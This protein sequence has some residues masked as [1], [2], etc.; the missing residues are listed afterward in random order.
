[1]SSL[2][3][4]AAHQMENLDRGV[5]AVKVTDG[6]FVSWRYLGT[7]DPS[8]GFNLYRDDRKV[9]NEVITTSTNY[10]DA[11]GSANSIY[12]VRAVINGVERGDS[13]KANVWGNQYLTVK[14]NRPGTNYTP[15]DMSVGDVDGDGTYELF[16][17]WDPS[18][19]QDVANKGKTDLVYIDC[20][21]MAGKQLWRINL[22][23]NIRAGAHYTQFQVFDYDGDGKAEMVCKTAPG[24]K[25]GNGKNIIMGNDDP[26]KDYRNGDGYIITGPEYLTAF[27][28]ETGAEM[29]TVAYKPARGNVSSWGDNYGNRVDRFLACTAYLDGVHP[30]VVMCRGYYTRA[31]LTAYDFK[32]GKL[33]E[34]W[35][36]DSPNKGQGA[37]GDG[38]HNLSVADAD[39]D[40]FDEIIY[41]SS[42]IDHD[43]KL[44]YRTG[45]AHGDAMHVSDMDPDSPGL[46]LFTVHESTGGKYGHNLS[47]LKDGKVL[48]GRAPGADDNG[49]GLAADIDASHRGF[50]FWSSAYGNI[51]DCKGTSI[52][53][54]PS[55]ANFRVYWDG[56]LQDELLDGNKIDKW[57]GNGTTRLFTATGSSSING[58]K[59]VPN[60]CADILGDWREEVIWY[61]SSNPSEIRI[62]TTTIATKNRLFTLMH[63][64]VYRCAI[65]WQNTA[66]NQPPHLGFYIGDGLQ[67]VKQPDIF[68]TGETPVQKPSLSISSES[69]TVFSGNAIE[70]ITISFGGSATGVEIAELPAGLTKT[71]IANGF[72][73]SG[74]STESCTIT[75]KSVGGEGDAVTKSIKINVISTTLKKVAYITDPAAANYKN[76]TKILSALK[77]CEDLYVVEIDANQATDLSQYDLIVISEVAGSGATL[78]PALE[79]I[80]KPMLSMKVH[81]YKAGAWDWAIEGYGDDAEATT[82]VVNNDMLKHPMFKDVTFTNGN[83]VRIL[84]E[85]DTKGLTF[86]NPESFTQ[87]SGEIKGIASIKG[88]TEVNILEASAGS[89]IAGTTLKNDF[90]QIGINS[91]S[92]ANVT[93]DGVSIIKNAC[94]Y[95]LGSEE[96]QVEAIPSGISTSISVF[97]N[98]VVDRLNIKLN[99]SRETEINVTLTNMIGTEVLHFSETISTGNNTISIE[100]NSIPA[101]TYVLGITT[102]DGIY[103][104]VKIIT[105]K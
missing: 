70:N 19:S 82:I 65:A 96:T 12:T 26:T 105:L 29:S 20:Y 79:G 3:I 40:G 56:D 30:S 71:A 76:D 84:S 45:Y 35:F 75:V 68:V 24:S 95:L 1:M 18:N 10:T 62:Y 100:R 33:V 39:G 22:G 91:S 98:P 17:K 9:N 81:A 93:D 25:D 11:G 99:A 32:D 89:T 4:S 16:V 28:G 69:Q 78:I 46:E 44:L 77:G 55:S 2:N 63:D 49:R 6:V 64:P 41:G 72:T 67:D 74:T 52:G 23:V 90:I 15:N 38:N 7:E 59:S 58:T 36:H 66:Y 14:L 42:T 31:T 37:Y 34:R 92:Y 27:N 61:N 80:D 43:G 85:V 48:V 50:E 57:N 47:S 73:I 104:D 21:T 13:K 94:Y 5:V 101:G 97:P 51:F 8:I 102:S 87:A 53:T 54:K 86:M 103:Y 88:L 83:E 60:L